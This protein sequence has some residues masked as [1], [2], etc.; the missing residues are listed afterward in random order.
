MVTSSSE[1]MLYQQ[2]RGIKSHTSTKKKT[3]ATYSKNQPVQLPKKEHFLTPDTP[4]IDWLPR[5]KELTWKRDMSKKGS[6]TLTRPA[7]R[8]GS[9]LAL[10]NISNIPFEKN[11]S[12]TPC[13]PQSRQS[14]R[15]LPLGGFS[16]GKVSSTV[17]KD[18]KIYKAE[19]ERKKDV[20]KTKK[21]KVLA[22]TTTYSSRSM[23]CC[24]ACG[25]L[26]C[27]SGHSPGT[28]QATVK[29]MII[30]HSLDD[31]DLSFADSEA[32]QPHN[33]TLRE[34]ELSLELKD[35]FPQDLSAILEEPMDNKEIESLKRTRTDIENCTQ[36]NK[37]EIVNPEL[38][39]HE[40]SDP[41]LTPQT[42]SKTD[43]TSGV[44]MTKPKQKRKLAYSVNTQPDCIL[45]DVISNK[46]KPVKVLFKQDKNWL[47]INP[48]S[49]PVDILL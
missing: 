13:R 41:D 20:K 29:S 31:L 45:L 38:Y 21:S 22:S 16:A 26:T 15:R 49:F 17:N 30:C 44:K 9:T 48:S 33:S 24:T 5:S 46:K 18:C 47:H 35:T 3:I 6:T 40:T 2:H 42:G 36:N 4:E 27:R 37:Q 11:L 28:K 1:R 8:Q 19:L 10:R 43:C 14:N 25:A 12:Q 34:D 32:L 7:T 39:T 23:S